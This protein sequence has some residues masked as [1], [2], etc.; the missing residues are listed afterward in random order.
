MTPTNCILPT[1]QYIEDCNVKEIFEKVKES[2]DFK[3]REI[4]VENF[5][6]TNRFKKRG[7][8]MGGIK[9]ALLQS[10]SS[11]A[12]AVVNVNSDGT[13]VIFHG[14]CEIGQGIHTKVI[15]KSR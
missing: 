3:N 6:K 7:I 1:G 9:F 14:G 2:S 11:G 4:E 5:N 15:Q 13:V 8:S 12:T 10:Y